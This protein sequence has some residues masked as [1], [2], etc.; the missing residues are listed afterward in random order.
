[1]EKISKILPPSRRTQYV[2][3]AKRK[4]TQEETVNNTDDFFQKPAGRV[5]LLNA[6]RVDTLLANEKVASDKVKV[7]SSEDSIPNDVAASPVAEKQFTFNESADSAPEILENLV[8]DKTSNPVDR[9]SIAS[10]KDA[11][12][13]VQSAPY[14]KKS[15]TSAAGATKN[16][17]EAKRSGY[18]NMKEAK[19]LQ[20]AKD[21]TRKFQNVQ[22]SINEKKE[23][24][25]AKPQSEAVAERVERTNDSAARTSP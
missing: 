19:Q 17:L 13:F 25:G 7:S 21:I 11:A 20:A 24:R 2:D 23:I 16:A 14:D 10:A 8:V 5:S 18:E 9:V 12:E 3:L 1:M 6:K 15:E 22:E 4:F